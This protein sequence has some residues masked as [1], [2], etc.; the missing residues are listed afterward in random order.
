[1]SETITSFLLVSEVPTGPVLLLWHSGDSLINEYPITDHD[2]WENYRDSGSASVWVPATFV[3]TSSGGI[4]CSCPACQRITVAKYM[5]P[6]CYG[7][8][9]TMPTA[10][11][12]CFLCRPSLTFAAFVSPV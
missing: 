1:M 4:V 5:S 10:C 9:I 8:R 3:N 11:F 12:T 7:G 6:S 2:Y